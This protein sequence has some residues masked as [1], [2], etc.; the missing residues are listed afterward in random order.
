MGVSV[1]ALPSTLEVVPGEEATCPIAIRNSGTVVDEFTF[2]ILG[3]A[4]PWTEVVPPSLHLLPATEGSVE[5]HLKPPRQ[6]STKAGAIAIGVKV[7]S[8]EDPE[9]STVVQGVVTVAPFTDVTAQLVP[10]TSRGWRFAEHTLTISSGSN[11]AVTV[12]VKADDPDDLLSFELPASVNIDL[13]GDATATVRVTARKL[14]LKRRAEPRPF[15]VTLQP[16]EAE[17]QDV[18]PIEVGGTLM[19]RGLI[20]FWLLLLLAAIIVLVIV[21]AATGHPVAAFLV[22]AALVVLLLLSS[23]RLR[24]LIKSQL[25]AGGKPGS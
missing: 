7:I 3:G 20:S 24:A 13:G 18:K 23:K 25:A 11:H 9:H 19:Q 8:T 14:L 17:S 1:S 6:P 22:V 5:L 10:Q 21:L 2:E 12:A 4:A 16:T 15:R